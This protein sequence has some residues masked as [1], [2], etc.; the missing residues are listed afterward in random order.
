MFVLSPQLVLVDVN[1]LELP[2]IILGAIVGML[3]IAAAVQGWFKSKLNI[4]ERFALLIGGLM[5]MDSAILHDLVGLTVIAVIFIK[6]VKFLS[7]RA[8]NN[9]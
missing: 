3:S 5:F 8:K 9:L 2:R 4:I 1:W 7:R 6:Q